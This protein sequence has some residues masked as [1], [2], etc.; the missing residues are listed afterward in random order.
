M[1]AAAETS[2]AVKFECRLIG[3]KAKIGLQINAAN[4]TG[5]TKVCNATCTATGHSGKK[6]EVKMVDQQLTPGVGRVKAEKFP[7]EAPLHE[8]QKLSNVKCE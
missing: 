4:D 2:D 3:G 7:S 8:D 5:K 6:V 1:P